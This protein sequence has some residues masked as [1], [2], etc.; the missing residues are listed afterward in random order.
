MTFA[1]SQTDYSQAHTWRINS[2]R[3]D[4]IHECTPVDCLPDPISPCR[5]VD[6]VRPLSRLESSRVVGGCKEVSR[7]DITVRVF[8]HAV[9]YVREKRASADLLV[10]ESPEYWHVQG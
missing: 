6:I 3:T 10:A 5:V 8:R 1:N 4:V 2:I 9:S 7:C